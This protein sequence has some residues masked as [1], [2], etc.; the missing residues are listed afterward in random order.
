MSEPATEATVPTATLL[1]QPTLCYA[2]NTPFDEGEKE[3]LCMVEGCSNRFHAACA[4][5]SRFTAEEEADWAC[6]HCRCWIPKGGDYS[7]TPV[8]ASK[9]RAT[10]VTFRKKPLANVTIS[11]PLELPSLDYLEVLSEFKFIR[12]EMKVMKDMMF[13][14]DCK[15]QA[16]MDKLATMSEA[17]AQL[18]AAVASRSRSVPPE[19]PNG[20]PGSS[21]TTY[22]TV[23]ASP[24]KVSNGRPEPLPPAEGE[25]GTLEGTESNTN[26]RL[27]LSENSD[28]H[29][30]KPSQRPQRPTSM[31]CNPTKISLK[32]VEYR[33]FI[34]LWN[35]VSGVEEVK[36]YLKELC[37]GDNFTVEELRAKGDYKSYKIGIPDA[38]FDRCFTV[39]AWPD[40][41]RLKVWMPFRGPYTVPGQ[42]QRRTKSAE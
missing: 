37:P 10:N 26:K 7:Q 34:H 22:A 32:A 28:G 19:D 18:N 31:R 33:K 15:L 4:G 8:G 20:Q 41:A 21:T 3:L 11:E 42:E 17:P 39:D 30:P 6:P 29:A 35:M 23:A 9:F 24:A 40:N 12:Q 2:C 38:H 14:H 36:E 16:L 13:Q 5:A 25:A 1:L 27:D